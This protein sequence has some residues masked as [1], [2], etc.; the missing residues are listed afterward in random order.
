MSKGFYFLKERQSWSETKAQSIDRD[1]YLRRDR[2][3]SGSYL[4]LDLLVSFRRKH[5]FG[6]VADLHDLGEKGL[7]IRGRRRSDLRH[8]AN[9]GQSVFPVAAAI[10]HGLPGYVHGAGGC[11]VDPKGKRKKQP[12]RNWHRHWKPFETYCGLCDR[13]SLLAGLY[14]DEIE[15]EHSFGI[16]L[17]SLF[18]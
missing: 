17:G 14:S 8:P 4:W 12:V 7:E 6:D 3:D 9:A 5:F 13:H 16:N 18:T 1:G 11:R 2:D 10:H 15:H